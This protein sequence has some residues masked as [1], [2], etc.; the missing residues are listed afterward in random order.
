VFVE[1]NDP[2]EHGPNRF[3]GVDERQTDS[4]RASLEGTLRENETR[5]ADED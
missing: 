4:Q 5:K 1:N 3:K 2:D